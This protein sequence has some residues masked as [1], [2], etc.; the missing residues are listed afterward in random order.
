MQSTTINA[1]LL[2]AVEA[3]LLDVTGLSVTITPQSTTS[4]ILVLLNM[5]VVVAASS[6]AQFN[7]VRNSAQIAICQFNKF[8]IS[9]TLQCSLRFQVHYQ[10]KL[11]C[12]LVIWI[13]HQRHQPLHI[14]VPAKLRNGVKQCIDL[15]GP[16]SYTDNATFQ[17]QQVSTITVYRNFRKLMMANIHDANSCD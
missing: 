9:G 15:I 5:Q 17:V 14:K 2:S 12:T 3:M 6:N 11:Y 10:M 4:K 1:P 16:Q 13:L 8:S 7:L